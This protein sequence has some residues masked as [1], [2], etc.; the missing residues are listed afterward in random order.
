VSKF[1]LWEL[2]R[3]L[4]MGELGARIGL[5]FPLGVV[6]PTYYQHIVESYLRKDRKL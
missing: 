5:H 1:N 4:F 3:E 6:L 2:F